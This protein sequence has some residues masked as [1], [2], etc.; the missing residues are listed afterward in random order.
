MTI[1]HHIQRVVARSRKKMH[2]LILAG[3][4]FCWL[5]LIGMDMH[6]ANKV[7]KMI[8]PLLSVTLAII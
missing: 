7:L 5:S 6:V 4:T 1:L 2:F 3:T 8:F